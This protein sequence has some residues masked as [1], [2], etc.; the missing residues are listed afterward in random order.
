[1]L[2]RKRF[3]QVRRDQRAVLSPK[4]YF[5]TLLS[6]INDETYVTKNGQFNLC[7]PVEPLK[8]IA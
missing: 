2:V 5:N 3:K 7:E 8:E 4:C 6:E 1:M